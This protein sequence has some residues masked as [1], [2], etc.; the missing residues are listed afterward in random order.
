M[1]AAEPARFPR[2]WVATIARPAR[3]AGPH[4]AEASVVTLVLPSVEAIVA[5]DTRVITNLALTAIPAHVASREYVPTDTRWRRAPDI[6]QV[7][8]RCPSIEARHTAAKPVWVHST[9]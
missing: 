2:T 5:D 1:L 8:S 6:V 3:L 7:L 4:N 9:Q